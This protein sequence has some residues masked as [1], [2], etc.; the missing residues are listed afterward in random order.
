[1]KDPYS[2]KKGQTD[3][4]QILVFL[5]D[6]TGPFRVNTSEKTFVDLDNDSGIIALGQL[7]SSNKDSD[8]VKF[9]LP[10]VYRDNSRIPTHIVLAA[11]SSRYGDYFTGG[12]GS[13]LL[14]DE[15][16]FVYDP[17]ELTE[18]EFNSVFSKVSAF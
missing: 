8:Y 9:T 11:A 5:T 1:M 10:I 14:I 7:N 16:E 12:V 15:F 17:A 13:V 18:S 4:S 2:D 6:W 3:E